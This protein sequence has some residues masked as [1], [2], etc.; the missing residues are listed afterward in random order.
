MH[1]LCVEG[2]NPPSRTC[3]IFMSV[4]SVESDSSGGGGRRPYGLTSSTK[5]FSILKN[6]QMSPVP[7]D[8]KPVQRNKCAW[9]TM[10]IWNLS[11]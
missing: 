3:G 10:R 6:K 9:Q 8:E 2:K 11:F 4:E 5:V 1:L 7:C